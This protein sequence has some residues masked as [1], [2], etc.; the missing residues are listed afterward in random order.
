MNRQ[1]SIYDNDIR[2]EFNISKDVFD[3][4]IDEMNNDDYMYFYLYSGMYFGTKMN[5]NC[6]EDEKLLSLNEMSNKIKTI[7]NKYLRRYKI[8]RILK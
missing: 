7:L 3:F 4:C 8:E 1:K 2:K 5:V 6:Y